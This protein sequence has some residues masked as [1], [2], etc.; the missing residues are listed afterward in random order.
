MFHFARLLGYYL[1]HRC[2]RWFCPPPSIFRVLAAVFRF[3]NKRYIRR[4]RF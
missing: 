3:T 1:A 4:R 2:A